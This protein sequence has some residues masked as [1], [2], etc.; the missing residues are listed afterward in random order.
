L[1]PARGGALR[2][3]ALAIA[4]TSE[5]AR[6]LIRHHP[7]SRADATWWGTDSI[8]GRHSR[9]TVAG[10]SAPGRRR[11]HA[12]SSPCRRHTCRG[13][14]LRSEPTWE[15]ATIV[16]RCARSL[17]A[18]VDALRARDPAPEPSRL[19]GAVSERRRRVEPGSVPRLSSRAS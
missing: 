16:Y 11:V 1:S 7:P 8:E 12:A 3:P 2:T 15:I 9:R 6:C 19:P 10:R 18:L 13:R 5:E 4:E 14:D 17:V